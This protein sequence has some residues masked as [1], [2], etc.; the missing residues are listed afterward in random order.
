MTDVTAVE[1]DEPME[2]AAPQPI[3]QGWASR[4]S[5]F[6]NPILVREVQQAVKGRVFFLLVFAALLFSVILAGVV[7][8]FHNVSYRS[9][10][11]AF[12]WGL[13]ALV[14]LAFFVVPM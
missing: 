14:P 10:Q 8:S 5:D 4:L 12:S 6:L 1:A 9:G 2:P 13:A 3:E 11:Q 7:A